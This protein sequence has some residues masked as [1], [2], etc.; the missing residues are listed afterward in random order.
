MVS[1]VRVARVAWAERNPVMVVSVA[2]VDPVALAV[3]AVT[4]FRGPRELS[5]EVKAVPAATAA[6]VATA[7]P[8]EPVAAAGGLAETALRELPGLV[9]LAVL[10]VGR[11]M[12][13]MVELVEPVTNSFGTEVTGVQVASVA[14]W[15]RAVP[16][17][18]ALRP[19]RREPAALRRRGVT[20][21]PGV[22]AGIQQSWEP[23]AVRVGKVATPAATAMVEPVVPADL[24]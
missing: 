10:A 2:R 3:E 19:A 6:L 9:A 24:G 14:P 11:A 5:P 20:A 16:V 8:A 17:G 13:A 23:L 4:G 22:L 7:E 18:S 1:V 21:A 15:V 12:L